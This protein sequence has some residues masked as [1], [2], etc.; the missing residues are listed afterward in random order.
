MVFYMERKF[1]F[2]FLLMFLLLFSA[3]A[4]AKSYSL[5]KAEVYME[6]KPDALVKVEENITFNF[7]GD[8]SFAFRDIP[9]GEWKIENIQVLENNSPL[10]FDLIN[11]G[12]DTRVKWYYNASNEKRTFTIKYDLKNAVHA[13]KDVAELNWKV[14]GE[15][16]DRPLQEL[17]GWIELPANVQDANSVYVWGHP[18]IN[19][20]IGLIENKK[21]LFQAFSIPSYQFVEIRTAFPVEMLS[22]KENAVTELYFGLPGIIEEE[23]NY[24]Y[25]SGS[26]YNDFGEDIG[27]K[28]FATIGLVLIAIIF[29]VFSRLNKTPLFQRVLAILLVALFFFYSIFLENLYVLLFIALEIALFFVL[30]HFF[31]REPK[32]DYNAFY[33]REIPYNYSPAVVKALFNAW[34]KK[35]NYEQMGA[36]LLDLCLKGKLKLEQIKKGG[37][38]ERDDF[39]IHVID[40]SNAGLP[41]SEKIMLDLIAEAAKGSYEGFIFKKFNKDKTPNELLLSELEKYLKH[42]RI[43]SRKIAEDWMKAVKEETEKF[44]FFSKRNGILPFALGTGLLVFI[45]G[46][47]IGVFALLA[48]FLIALFFMGIFPDSLPNRTKQGALHYAKWNNLK[49][50]LNDFSNL[51]EMPPTAIVLWEQFLVYSIPLGVAKKVQKAMDYVFKDFTGEY[52]GR[53]FIGSYAGFSYATFGASVSSFSSAFASATSTSGSGGFGAGGGAG[54]GGGGGGAG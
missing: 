45:A 10:Q 27:F 21:V 2:V 37:L 17:Y 9:K 7:S 49:K 20:K 51:K 54:G 15:G 36:E 34:T 8:F 44:G 12:S 25:I 48:V 29:I 41:E 13:Y 4:Y 16:W 46:I 5:E 18:E 53:I 43:K 1:V 32:I 42:N 39:K 30:W 19:G 14:W 35:P 24:S 28:I 22:S 50:F 3:N 6:I 47:S 23:K 31:G 33:E 40:S 52:N 26:G 38:F 11:Q